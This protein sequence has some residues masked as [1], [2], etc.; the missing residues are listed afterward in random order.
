M[1]WLLFRLIF[2]YLKLLI[3]V[4]ILVKFGFFPGSQGIQV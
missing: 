1:E 2:H 4:V 3:Y